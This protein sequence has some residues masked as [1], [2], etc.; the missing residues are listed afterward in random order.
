MAAKSEPE[1]VNYLWNL[2]PLP[3]EVKRR[4][5]FTRLEEMNQQYFC[6]PTPR[7]LYNIKY[8]KYVIQMMNLIQELQKGGGDLILNPTREI[9]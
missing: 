7:L 5:A 8:M 9:E 6:Y 3:F 1:L 2:L 4:E